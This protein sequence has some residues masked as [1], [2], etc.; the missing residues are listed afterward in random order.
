MLQKQEKLPAI[1]EISVEECVIRVCLCAARLR[2]A[3]ICERVPELGNITIETLELGN[4]TIVGRGILRISQAID[5]AQLL[6]NSLRFSS[7]GDGDYQQIIE[8]VC[9]RHRV[10]A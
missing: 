5:I 9:D 7:D 4:I 2:R 1:G 6:H 10:G 3:L 8:I